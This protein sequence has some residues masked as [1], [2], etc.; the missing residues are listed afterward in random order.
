MTHAYEVLSARLEQAGV[1]SEI[2]RMNSR[3]VAIRVFYRTPGRTPWFWVRHSSLGWS[4]GDTN[5][6]RVASSQDVLESCVARAL[7]KGHPD[8]DAGSV[9][10]D[11]QSLWTQEEFA[12][13]ERVWKSVGWKALDESASTMICD[14][15]EKEF[16]YPSERFLAPEPSATWDFSY[17]YDYDFIAYERSSAQLNLAGLTCLRACLGKSDSLIALDWNHTSYELGNN[18]SLKRGDLEE[19][20][21]S[22]FSGGDYH[23]FVAADFRLGVVS[24]PSG[25]VC[26]FG[27]QMPQKMALEVNRMT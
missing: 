12:A 19:W 15:F 20:P 1:A 11:S 22:I 21:I 13:E 8:K 27:D 4:I 3:W 26:A 24:D 25:V 14:A 23:I 16:A 7:G 2:F 18:A 9:N 17:L 5:V 6:E 10:L